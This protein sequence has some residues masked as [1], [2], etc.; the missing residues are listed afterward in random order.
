MELIEQ[1]QINKK[2]DSNHGKYLII[3]L[4]F[5]YA[6]DIFGLE[7]YLMCVLFILLIDPLFD[8]L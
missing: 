8:H 2:I 1:L 4:I 6:E 3:Y 5:T 7:N